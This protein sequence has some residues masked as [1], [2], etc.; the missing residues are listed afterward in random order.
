M[1]KFDGLVGHLGALPDTDHLLSFLAVAEHGAVGRA[2]A[3]LGRTQS[4]ISVQIRRLEEALSARLFHRE[5]R[6]VRLTEAGE[7]LLPT[8]R[9][10]VDDLRRM[11]ANFAEPVTGSVRVGIPDDFGA[12]LL[13]RILR[14][15]A[16]A[17]PLV[18]IT[19][20]CGFSVGFPEAVRRGELDLAVYTA[21]LDES[22]GETILIEPTVW[23]ARRDWS[24]PAEGGPVALALFDRACWWRDVAVETMAG[25]PWPSRI[26]FTSESVSGVKAAISSGLGVGALARSAL[27]PE[28]RVLT[29]AEGFP[30]L[31]ESR[32]VLIRSAEARGE[33]VA[34]MAAAAR[35]G[36][37]ALRAEL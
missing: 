4:A 37:Q 1:N 35:D 29:E 27:T 18:E 16:A 30:P 6:G 31:P 12:P 2:A 10:V 22:D 5:P 9:R 36:F 26:A 20:R 25:S 15:F 8:A 24:P 23:A 19:A 13:E 7:C 21:A 34:A 14:G 28:L 3:V 32:L 33:A 11:R 17:H